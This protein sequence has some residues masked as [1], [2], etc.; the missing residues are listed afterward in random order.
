LFTPADE[1]QRH[2]VKMI[3][4]TDGAGDHRRAHKSRHLWPRCHRNCSVRPK[5]CYHMGCNNY[6]AHKSAI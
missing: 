5:Y 3:R 1:E 2:S 6:Y 4:E